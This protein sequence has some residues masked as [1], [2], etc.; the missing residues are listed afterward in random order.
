MTK[1]AI[2]RSISVF[3]LAGL[4]EIGGGYMLWVAI[5]KNQPLWL[6]LFGA[7]LLTTYGVL[8]TLQPANFGRTY[9]AYG[10]IFVIMALSWGWLV[11]KTKPDIY[12]IIGALIILL[13][14]TIIFY[15]P[16]NVNSKI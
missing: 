10:G 5:K 4:C 11:D 16:H 3:V 9:A 15:A 2:F 12:D 7:I 14:A 6:G 8:A 1:E 13:G